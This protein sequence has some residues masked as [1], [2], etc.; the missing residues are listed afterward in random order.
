MPKV[1]ANDSMILAGRV[2]S[3]HY[4]ITARESESQPKSSQSRH[5]M[6]QSRRYVS[7]AH[8]RGAA[9]LCCRLRQ[10][11]GAAPLAHTRIGSQ[12]ARQA[13][14]RF[15]SDRHAEHGCMMHTTNTLDVRRSSA[16]GM[17]QAARAPFCPRCDATAITVAAEHSACMHLMAGRLGT[18][19]M[20]CT[21]HRSATQSGV[22]DRRLPSAS[23]AMRGGPGPGYHHHSAVGAGDASG[24]G[25]APAAAAGVGTAA[26]GGAT[27]IG[28]GSPVGSGCPNC[29]CPCAC[30]AACCASCDA[31][32]SSC[33]CAC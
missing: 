2:T 32:A 16:V 12:I 13:S 5:S 29:R 33:C 24:A 31:D 15:E 1:L 4:R 3:H 8:T 28:A 17:R 19:M 18:I 14:S 10:S 26:E 20:C 23:T 25:P 22:E 11:C 7:G 27:G 6:G 9:P 21:C 30:A